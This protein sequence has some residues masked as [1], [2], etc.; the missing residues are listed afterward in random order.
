MLQDKSIQKVFKVIRA[1][2]LY[3]DIYILKSDPLKIQ[4]EK[5]ENYKKQV[6]QH[7]Q[8]KD[9]TYDAI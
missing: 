7:V 3:G 2:K 1:R 4:A 5:D 8:S 9:K 6:F